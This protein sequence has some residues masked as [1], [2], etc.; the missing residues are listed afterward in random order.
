[1]GIVNAHMPPHMLNARNL[2]LDVECLPTRVTHPSSDGA[3]RIGEEPDPVYWT[4]YDLHMIE[5]DARAMRRA[6]MYSTIATYGVR[7]SQLIAN[8]A[9]AL[10]KKLRQPFVSVACDRAEAYH[11]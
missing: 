1:M 2:D 6:R 11:S 5:R 10:W 9:R 7:L 3:A 8:S 4:A